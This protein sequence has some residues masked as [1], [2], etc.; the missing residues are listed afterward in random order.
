MQRSPT[1]ESC[2]HRRNVPYP[3]PGKPTR[4]RSVWGRSRAADRHHYRASGGGESPVDGARWN[5]TTADARAA[6]A[7]GATSP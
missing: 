1:G 3:R 5:P 7:R 6:T 2:A 4:H